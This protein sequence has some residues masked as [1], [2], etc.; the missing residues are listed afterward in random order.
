MGSGVL[1]IA[2]AKTDN[3]FI[4]IFDLFIG[5]PGGLFPSGLPL[6]TYM[7]LSFH[8]YLPH[9]PPIPFLFI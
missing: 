3:P 9:T 2:T 1:N 8:P 4:V 5:L 6:N 7:F